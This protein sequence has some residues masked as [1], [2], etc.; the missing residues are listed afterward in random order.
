MTAMERLQRVVRSMLIQGLYISRRF[1]S[2]S[3]GGA[4]HRRLFLMQNATLTHF[5]VLL[6]VVFLLAVPAL[7]QTPADPAPAPPAAAEK[8]PAAGSD[9][10]DRATQGAGMPS[11]QFL[12]SQDDKQM[13]SYEVIGASVQN[14]Q[15]ESIGTIDALLFNVDDRIVA[16]I[17]S[18]G[19]FLGIG[20][21]N[22]AVNWSEFQFQ[23]ENK[24]AIVKLSRE[25][26]EAAPAFEDRQQ[27]QAQAE[28]E[29]RRRE[30]EQ[31]Q[32]TQGAV[33]QPTQ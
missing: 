7:A 18:V 11:G 12:T 31:R 23:P 22:V 6:A 9:T 2:R 16:G 25:Q 19:G 14:P 32:Q 1:N 30:A 4:E 20:A 29:Q 21:K 8:S 5:L 26:L 3:G 13:V 17:V 27:Q 24:I 15:E 10:S 33:P 28:L